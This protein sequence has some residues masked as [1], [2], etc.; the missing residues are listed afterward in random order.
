MKHCKKCRN[1]RDET[2]F[3]MN[4]KN[5]QTCNHCRT[6]RKRRLLTLTDCQE[7]AQGKGGEC[8]SAEY[9]HS[10]TKMAWKCSEGHEWQARFNDSDF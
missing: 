6:T 5:Y 8:L 2:E 7:Y 4:S 10:V 9:K 1:N 3:K